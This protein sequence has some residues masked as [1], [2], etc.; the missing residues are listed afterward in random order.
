LPQSRELVGALT[1]FLDRPQS[2]PEAILVK[3]GVD[4]RGSILVAVVPA[5]DRGRGDHREGMLPGVRRAQL[6]ALQRRLHL[7]EVE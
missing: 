2:T 4:L 3:A 7:N 5:P 1:S 6:F